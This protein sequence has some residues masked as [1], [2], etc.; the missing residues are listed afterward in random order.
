MVSILKQQDQY[1]KENIDSQDYHGNFQMA[2]TQIEQQVMQMVSVGSKRG[3]SIYDPDYKYPQRVK[4][5][6]NE[7]SHCHDRGCWNNGIPGGR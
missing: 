1:D 3:P 7:D 4:Q 6:N 5:W 2:V